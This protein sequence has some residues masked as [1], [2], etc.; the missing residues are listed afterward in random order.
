M[1]AFLFADKWNVCSSRLTF[2][3][4]TI[5]CACRAQQLLLLRC[6]LLGAFVASDKPRAYHLGH[7]L[8][9]QM[10]CTIGFTPHVGVAARR[11]RINAKKHCKPPCQSTMN[12]VLNASGVLVHRSQQSEDLQRIGGMHA[13]DMIGETSNCS[14]SKESSGTCRMHSLAP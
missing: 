5:I 4:I 6:F 3:A 7:L 9:F 8:G 12:Q 2:S 11:A 14:S 1:D 10:L 13:I